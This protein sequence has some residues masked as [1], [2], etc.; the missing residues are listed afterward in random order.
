MI[1]GVRI[2]ASTGRA[3]VLDIQMI[4]EGLVECLD[5]VRSVIMFVCSEMSSLTG[6]FGT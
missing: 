6:L 3:T 5:R 2:A 1:S 4:F